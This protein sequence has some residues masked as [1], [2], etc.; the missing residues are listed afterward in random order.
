MYV[1]CGGIFGGGRVSGGGGPTPQLASRLSALGAAARKAALPAASPG[2]VHSTRPGGLS[3][4]T[5]ARCRHS[6][7]TETLAALEQFVLKGL[8]DAKSVEVQEA[9]AVALNVI[10][11]SSEGLEAATRLMPVFKRLAFQTKIPKSLSTSMP[12]TFLETETADA[13]VSREEFESLWKERI[14]K[15]N[16]TRVRRLAKVREGQLGIGACVLAY[17]YTIP[18]WVPEALVLLAASKVRGSSVMKTLSLFRQSHQDG[19]DRHH[20]WKFTTEQMDV[21]RDS[22]L[23]TNYYA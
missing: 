13:H 15:R 14:A 5:H 19:W 3:P 7:S 17:P 16:R 20:K 22:F 8:A 4:G 23:P 11:M 9:S 6:L 21:L 18:E 2:S 12:E 10:V 1:G